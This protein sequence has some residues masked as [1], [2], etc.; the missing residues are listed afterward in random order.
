MIQ[1]NFSTSISIILLILAS[2]NKKNYFIVA[3]I[4]SHA[5]R[6]AN[7][8]IIPNPTLRLNSLESDLLNAAIRLEPA[9]LLKG[10][11]FY[12]IWP[13]SRAQAQNDIGRIE[14]T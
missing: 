1:T 6:M 11:A 4:L 13:P 5:G 7:D 9:F 8:E 3:R 10:I 14:R 12:C 2:A